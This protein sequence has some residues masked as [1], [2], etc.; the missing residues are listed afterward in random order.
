[1]IEEDTLN[2]K[3]LSSDDLISLN[4][5]IENKLVRILNDWKKIQKELIRILNYGEKFFNPFHNGEFAIPQLGTE[6]LEEKFLEL[7]SQYRTLFSKRRKILSQ[8]EQ[9]GIPEPEHHLS[10]IKY[11]ERRKSQ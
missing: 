3:G 1:M 5:E 4:Q 6:P 10:W 8:L 9:K 7:C 11:I 2:I